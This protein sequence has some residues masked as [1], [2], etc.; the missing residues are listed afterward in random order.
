MEP[1]AGIPRGGFYEGGRAQDANSFKARPYP[2][3]IGQLRIQLGQQGIYFLPPGRKGQIP[4]RRRQHTPGLILA[5]QVSQPAKQGFICPAVLEISI[6][7]QAGAGDG[8]EN[9]DT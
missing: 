5:A 1:V 9:Q 8:A 4:D 2:P 7:F 6:E 3:K